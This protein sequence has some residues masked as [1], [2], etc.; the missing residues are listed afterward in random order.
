VERE[1][2]IFSPVAEVDWCHWTRPV[3]EYV[4]AVWQPALTKEQTQSL[5]NVQ[6]RVLQI[7]IGTSSSPTIDNM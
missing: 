7:T 3:L 5:E 4:C 1:R 6:Q 2:K